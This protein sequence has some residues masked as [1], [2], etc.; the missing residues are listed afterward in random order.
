MFNPDI[1]ENYHNLDA[2]IAAAKIHPTEHLI[3]KII[4]KELD[5][6]G[7]H[8]EPAFSAFLWRKVFHIN[9]QDTAQATLN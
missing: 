8:C 4:D 5:Y 2:L 7:N 9:S 1:I 6:N 3:Q